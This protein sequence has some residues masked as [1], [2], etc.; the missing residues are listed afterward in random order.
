ML[1]GQSI[2]KS[3]T[4][5]A[6]A[7]KVWDALTKPDLIV[8]WMAEPEMEL[9]IIT[10]W[11]IGHPLVMKGFHHVNFVNTGIVLKFDTNKTL[12][13]TY[14]SSLSRLPDKS[15]IIH[16]SNFG[17]HPWAGRRNC[18]LL[19]IISLLKRSLNMSNFTGIQRWML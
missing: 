12:Q 10:D 6:P 3:V 17:W 16:T 14:L 8:Q 7:H 4:I 5:N 18:I 2:N 11:R 13:Y 9:Q 15:E 19:F 1:I